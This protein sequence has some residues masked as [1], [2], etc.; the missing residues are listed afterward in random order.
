MSAS[1]S[2]LLALFLPMGASALPKERSRC[3]EVRPLRE[4]I[5]GPSKEYPTWVIKKDLNVPGIYE[6]FLSLRP[7]PFF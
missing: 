4:E 6:V 3:E 7:A 5:P 2:F 1:I